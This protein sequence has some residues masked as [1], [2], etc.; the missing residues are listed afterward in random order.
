VVDAGRQLRVTLQ[1]L[2]HLGRQFESHEMNCRGLLL[3]GALEVLVRNRVYLVEITNAHVDPVLDT[4]KLMQHRLALFDI[5]KLDHESRLPVR[6]V[7]NQRIVGIQ[8]LVNALGLEDAFNA[9]HL[10]HLVLH[11]HAVFE[12]QRCIRAECEPAIAFV[13]QHAFAKFVTLLGVRFK[14]KEIVPG[15]FLHGVHIP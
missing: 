12:I 7:R 9:Q 1:C 13:R 15:Q 8:F 2:H 14:A 6:A 11:C 4:H 3:V 10:L 5:R